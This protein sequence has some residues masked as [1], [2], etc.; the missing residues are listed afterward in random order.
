ML[1]AIKHEIAIGTFQYAKYFPL[2]KNALL[3]I[4]LTNKTVSQALDEY[5]Q[6]ARR[7]C[8]MSTWKNYKSAIEHHLKPTFGHIRLGTSAPA[9][10]KTGLAH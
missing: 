1:S 9:R 3:G 6:A 4:K 8:E 7:T 2:S 5:L 10:S